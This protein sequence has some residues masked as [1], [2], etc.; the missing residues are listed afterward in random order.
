MIPRAWELNGSSQA[1]MPGLFDEDD[2]MDFDEEIDIQPKLTQSQ[3][4][5]ISD[6]K[7]ILEKHPALKDDIKRTITEE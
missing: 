2:Y 1:Y 4:K 5:H 3:V 7:D 6:V